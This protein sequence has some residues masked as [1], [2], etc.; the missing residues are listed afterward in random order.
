MVGNRGKTF[1][2]VLIYPKD[3]DVVKIAAELKSGLT[4]DSL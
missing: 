1:Q 2:F 3:A 4:L